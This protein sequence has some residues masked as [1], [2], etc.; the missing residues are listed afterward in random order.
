MI[1]AAIIAAWVVFVVGLLV[2][3][4]LARSAPVC[5]CGDLDCGGD[6]IDW[7]NAS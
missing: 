4:E 1:G 6:C 7:S 5:T 3:L 2:G